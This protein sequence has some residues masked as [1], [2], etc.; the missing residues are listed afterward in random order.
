MTKYND[1]VV[2]G[3][4]GI[5]KIAILDPNATQ[6]DP[7]TGITVMKEV[8]TIAGV[9]P[10]DE[11]PNNPGA[12]REWCINSAAIDPATFSVLANSEDGTLYR[13]DLRTNKLTQKIVL[14]GGLGEAYTPTVIGADGT[15]Y[16][17]NQATL[18]AVGV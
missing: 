14:T 10:D 16:A 9:T 15:V 18:W 12:V 2:L 4:S 8:L 17:I 11:F 1:Y 6:T 13:W 3:G 7:T 5:N